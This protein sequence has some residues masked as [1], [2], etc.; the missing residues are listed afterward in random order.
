MIVRMELQQLRCVVA[1]AD[2]LHFGRAAERLHVAQQSV[3]EQVRRLERE[4]GTPLFVRTS[5]HVALT[6]AG[7]AFLPAARH[8]L[9]AVDEAAE[10]AHRV[11]RGTSGQLRV[12]Y[13]GDLGQRLM[14]HA[15]PRL[16]QLD[17]PVQ[18][19]ARADE[20][21]ATADRVG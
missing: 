20:H 5:R 21:P 18:S 7:A 19:P 3:S 12:G 1:V 16:G 9:V 15:V 8:A 17:A 10:I 13:G 14:Q 4:L 11:A 2:E 6:S